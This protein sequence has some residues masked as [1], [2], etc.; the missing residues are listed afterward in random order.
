MTATAEQVAR[1]R[2]IVNESDATTYN[3]AA[4]RIYIERYPLL[5]A[6]GHEPY[7]ESETSPGTLEANDDWTAT[8]D[9]NAA[10]ADIWAEKAAALAS[11]FD[12]SAGGQNFTRSQGYQMMMQQSR[13]YRAR[14]AMGTIRAW[15][16]PRP[17]ADEDLSN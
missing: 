8:Y 7:V 4:L 6:L 15:P 13:Y 17:D 9:L 1:L 14:R 3:D 10:A 5:D 12:F 2:R 11:E 16:A